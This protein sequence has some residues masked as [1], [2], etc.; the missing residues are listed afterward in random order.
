MRRTAVRRLYGG[1]DGRQRYRLFLAT[2][3]RL[4]L[5]EADHLRA[6]ARHDAD[7]GWAFNEAHEE[8]RALTWIYL[9]CAQASLTVLQMTKVL[10]PALRAVA[11]SQD[12]KAGD[13]FVE[14]VEELLAA[15]RRGALRGLKTLTQAYGD[16]GAE[17]LGLPADLLPSFQFP[18]PFETTPRSYRRRRSPRRGSSGCGPSFGPTRSRWDRCRACCEPVRRRGEDAVFRP[19]GAPAL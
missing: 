13:A 5:A 11:Y 18:T 9:V 2:A 19:R 4:D 10:E 7:G 17:C 16:V 3:A 15:A 8:C 1:M 14:W 6:S 12:P